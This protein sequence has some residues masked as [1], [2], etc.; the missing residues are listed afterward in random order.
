M[1][2]V[3][4][5]LSPGNSSAKRTVLIR[6]S[7]GT[8][9]ITEMIIQ[10]NSPHRDTALKAFDKVSNGNKSSTRGNN[11]PAKMNN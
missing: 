5:D 9:D 10:N 3:A 4:G 7:K 11:G 8:S 6:K 2:D 1:V